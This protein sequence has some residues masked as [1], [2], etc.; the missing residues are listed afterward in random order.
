MV[1][2]ALLYKYFIDNL[3]NF[4]NHVI[5]VCKQDVL[6][7]ASID[8]SQEYSGVNLTSS[9]N[10]DLSKLVKLCKFNINNRYH[11]LQLIIKNIFNFIYSFRSI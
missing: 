7:I 1:L 4:P 2:I 6:K 9:S 8:I 11:I 5:R 10:I 3:H